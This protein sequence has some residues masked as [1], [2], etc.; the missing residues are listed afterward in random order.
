MSWKKLQKEIVMS[1]TY[2][3]DS[4]M[5]TADAK[6]NEPKDQNNRLYWRANRRRLESEGLWDLLLTASGKLD[7]SKHGGPSERST[8]EMAHRGVF[9]NVSR[10][11]PDDFSASL[12]VPGR[13]SVERRPLHHE[14]SST[15]A[16]LPENH[17]DL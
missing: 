16:S 12:G 7:L 11:T 13:D 9:G 17:C 4:S 15:T 1:H 8:N 5:P 14:C 3:L 10:M 6:I 2:Q